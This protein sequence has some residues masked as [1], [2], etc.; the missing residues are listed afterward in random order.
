VK[1][2]PIIA[3]VFFAWTMPMQAGMKDDLLQQALNYVL[4][5]TI[6]PK[7]APQI[8][9]QSSCAVIMRDP[10]YPR[11]IRYY[12]GRIRPDNSRISK[13]YAGTRTL[14]ELDVEGDEV[15]IEY[16]GADKTSGVQGYRSAQ[17]TL[18]G[19]IEQTEKALKI[20]EQ[21]C[22]SERSKAPFS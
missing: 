20:I 12:F 11:F 8:V 2:L 4:T 14:Y 16:F 1:E 3:I 10:R 6:E 18:P 17:I 5:G 15:V 19:N 22:K 13:K 21:R 9:D 7:E